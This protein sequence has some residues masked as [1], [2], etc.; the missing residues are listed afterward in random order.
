MQAMT[1]VIW[2]PKKQADTLQGFR[3]WAGYSGSSGTRKPSLPAKRSNRNETVMPS[4]TG[5]WMIVLGVL[6]GLSGL[7][8]LPAG[9]GL[10]GD[11]NLLGFGMSLFGLGMLMISTGVY[12]KTLALRSGALANAP[13]KEADNSSRR[14]RTSC[15]RCRNETPV[16]HCKVHQLHLCAA[17]LGE[18]YDFRTC[19]YVPSTRRLENKIAKTMVARA[20]A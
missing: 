18:H 1:S 5:T 14:S 12:L 7:V 6:L 9:L 4:R 17:C 8:V 3:K 15:D 13:A 19:V 2:K 11:R 20:H 10:R 16:V